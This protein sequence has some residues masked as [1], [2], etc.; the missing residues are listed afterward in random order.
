MFGLCYPGIQRNRLTKKWKKEEIKPL[1]II[2]IIIFIL[3][4]FFF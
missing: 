2:F 4:F 3:L 1:F